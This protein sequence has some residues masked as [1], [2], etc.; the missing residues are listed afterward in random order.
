[1][2][3]RYLLWMCSC[4][5]NW[6]PERAIGSRTEERGLACDHQEVDVGESLQLVVEVHGQEAGWYGIDQM[7]SMEQRGK[8]AT[9]TQKTSSLGNSLGGRVVGVEDLGEGAEPVEDGPG[10][11]VP[12]RGRPPVSLRLHRPSESDR[13]TRTKTESAKE[14]AAGVAIRRLIGKHMGSPALAVLQRLFILMARTNSVEG[15]AKAA[16]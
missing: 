4:G 11:R 5:M 13:S 8:W 15:P 10:R 2:R 12:L 16:F 7:S 14:M 9:M 1:M 6:S 3:P